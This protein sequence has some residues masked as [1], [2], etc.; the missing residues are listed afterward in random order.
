MLDG[1]ETK[2]PDIETAKALLVQQDAT[3][4]KIREDMDALG[5]REDNETVTLRTEDGIE[6]EAEL[7]P[8]GKASY[9][10]IANIPVKSEYAPELATVEEMA[11][12][13]KQKSPGFFS[14][15]C[16]IFRK[17]ES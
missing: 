10:Q 14:R 15:L 2:V 7:V 8:V 6:Y 5:L 9:M 13:E 17:D 3:R 12:L 4:V 11:K 1:V 16:N